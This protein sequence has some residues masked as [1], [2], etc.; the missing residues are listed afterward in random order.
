MTQEGKEA[1]KLKECSKT[2]RPL[3]LLKEL[4]RHSA[5]MGGWGSTSTPLSVGVLQG[6]ACQQVPN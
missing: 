2:T 4:P 1:D 3:F 5:M 6:L